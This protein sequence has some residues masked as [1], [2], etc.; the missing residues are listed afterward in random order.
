MFA[1]SCEPHGLTRDLVC[2]CRPLLANRY[3]S[4]AHVM[5]SA[6]SKGSLP[7]YLLALG[8]D[9]TN[10]AAWTDLSVA[11][12]KAGKH[13]LAQWAALGNLARNPTEA[14]HFLA[15]NSFM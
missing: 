13:K 2:P 4:A 5:S 6:D 9:R 7:L 11:A 15:A 1:P 3:T 12:G 14:S 8:A 10:V